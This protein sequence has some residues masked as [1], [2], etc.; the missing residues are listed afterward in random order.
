MH[1][2]IRDH[3]HWLLRHSSCSSDLAPSDFHFVSKS[4]GIHEGTKIS[5]RCYLH[6]ECMPAG[7]P[8]KIKKFFH[9]GIRALENRW[10][11]CISVEGGYVGKWQSMILIM[12]ILLLTENCI[13]LQDRTKVTT[14]IYDHDGLM[15][16]R[17]RAFYWYENRC[18]PRDCPKFLSAPYYLRNR[19]WQSYTNFK[20]CTGMHF[21]TIDC[22]KSPLTISGKVDAWA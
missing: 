18:V 16:S 12:I 3:N 2:L 10:T 19:Q 5:W 1:L 6:C 14:C 20:F 7:W 17:I 11:K 21:N 13:R 8:I 4:E 9:I 22:N 15:G